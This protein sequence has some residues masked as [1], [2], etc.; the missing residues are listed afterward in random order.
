[1][2]IMNITTQGRMSYQ[3]TKDQAL[4]LWLW[5]CLGEGKTQYSSDSYIIANNSYIVSYIEGA[6]SIIVLY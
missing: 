2:R 4:Q 5:Q 6:T 3:S 1:M